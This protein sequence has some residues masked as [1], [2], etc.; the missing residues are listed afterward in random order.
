MYAFD[1]LYTLDGLDFFDQSTQSG[2]IM[3]HDRQMALEETIVG[4]DIDGSQ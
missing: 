3:N 2:E 1:L 4:V